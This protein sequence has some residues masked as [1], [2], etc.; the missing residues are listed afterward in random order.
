M[1]ARKERDNKFFMALK[2]GDFV[3]ADKLIN[4][5]ANINVLKYTEVHVAYDWEDYETK[6]T[7]NYL[8]LAITQKRL[9]ILE[10]LLAH[11]A[12]PQFCFAEILDKLAERS[13]HD[14]FKVLMLIK[15]YINNELLYLHTNAGKNL[16]HV[17]AEKSNPSSLCGFNFHHASAPGLKF[18]LSCQQITELFS[19]LNPNEFFINRRDEMG[20][21][22]IHNA[23]KSGNVALAKWL[24]QTGLLNLRMQSKEGKTI[25]E[26][27]A[28][29]SPEMLA[30]M[31]VDVA[32]SLYSTRNQLLMFKPAAISVAPLSVP[33][34]NVL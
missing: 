3:A 17:L 12:S 1:N 29:S 25:D 33:K 4:E 15:Q 14:I 11:G 19:E 20:E 28:S 13:S 16:L 2:E 34:M 23:I 30:I 21:A 24:F 8:P 26:L 31:S 18:D 10:Y 9:D 6:V 27:M 32:E 22:P 5:G 7:I